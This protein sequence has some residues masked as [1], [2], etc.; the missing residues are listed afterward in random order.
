M[1]YRGYFLRH[2]TTESW[3]FLL[4]KQSTCLT[5]PEGRCGTFISRRQLLD[6]ADLLFSLQRCCWLTAAKKALRFS[7]VMVH[8]VPRQKGP[9]VL[10]ENVRLYFL[11]LVVIEERGVCLDEC[12]HAAFAL[13]WNTAPQKMPTAP[14]RWTSPRVIFSWVWFYFQ[15]N[16][17]WKPLLPSHKP[18]RF[19]AQ[20]WG[21]WSGAGDG[22]EGVCCWLRM[23]CWS[24]RTPGIEKET[25]ICREQ[26]AEPLGTWEGRDR[27]L[28]LAVLGE[29]SFLL[30]VVSAVSPL[31]KSITFP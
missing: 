25:S 22:C 24:Q 20:R 10:S 4:Y 11:Q 12:T 9:G 13:L 29:A 15:I 3:C 27:C 5:A 30:A 8:A 16:M 17:S 19:S 18:N 6:R 2:C 7:V 26:L 21:A 14:S 1:K 31:L 28:Y 23:L